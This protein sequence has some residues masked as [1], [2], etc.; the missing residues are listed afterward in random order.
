MPQ[1]EDSLR[2][3]LPNK[4]TA[5]QKGNH[6]PNRKT[7]PRKKIHLENVFPT[8]RL[9]HTANRKPDRNSCPRNGAYHKNG[10]PTGRLT[11]SK[12]QITQAALPQEQDSLRNYMS[13]YLVI[14]TSKCFCYPDFQIMLLPWFSICFCYRPS[15][16]LLPFICLL[17]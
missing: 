12:S 15:C 4:K 5:T 8:G 10:F 9:T 17:P 14:L 2:K 3:C 11:P 7:C 1:R 16:L 13:I 6:E